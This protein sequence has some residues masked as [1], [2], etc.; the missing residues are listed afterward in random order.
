[1]SLQKKVTTILRVFLR[2]LKKIFLSKALFQSKSKYFYVKRN[3]NPSFLL[4]VSKCLI[5]MCFWWKEV[6]FLWSIFEV[7]KGFIF[8]PRLM[9]YL[10]SLILSYVDVHL[11]FLHNFK[12][13]CLSFDVFFLPIYKIFLTNLIK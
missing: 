11:L 9:F 6:A 8:F 4:E 13:L 2:H 12:H 1:M 7:W 10:I 3:I 5:S